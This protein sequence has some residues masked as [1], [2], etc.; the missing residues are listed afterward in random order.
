MSGA[1]GADPALE[2]AL[3]LAPTPHALAVQLLRRFALLDEPR[4][5]AAMNDINDIARLCRDKHGPMRN[6]AMMRLA[7]WSI[8]LP[9]PGGP[10]LASDTPHDVA[11]A[12]AR[13]VRHLPA[14]N[15]KLCEEFSTTLMRYS[16]AIYWRQ[17][18]MLVYLCLRLTGLVG[19][20]EAFLSAHQPG[21]AHGR[22][23]TQPD[24]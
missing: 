24:Q 1:P 9:A 19:G 6:A 17:H 20:P 5:F 11:S 16:S 2:R 12:H 10:D 22:S 4:Q 21:V 18:Q 8:R 3:E 14:A 23:P 15:R 13:L 7:A